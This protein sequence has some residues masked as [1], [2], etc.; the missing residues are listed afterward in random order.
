MV[1]SFHTLLIIV[2]AFTMAEPQFGHQMR[3]HFL[4]KE[5]LVN[6]NA[7]AFGTMCRPAYESQRKYVDIM[8]SNPN[9]WFR[10]VYQEPLNRARTR[11]SKYV[12]AKEDD[13]VIVENT[14]AA[15][16]AIMRSLADGLNLGKG[17]AVLYMNIAR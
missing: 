7:A 14:S 9:I 16:N 1:S 8:E 15:I 5:D 3:K 2:V 12:N 4:M 17:D 11:I 10:G 6:L 13:L